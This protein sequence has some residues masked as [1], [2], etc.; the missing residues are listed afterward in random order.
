M[1]Q[2]KNHK[3]NK[4]ISEIEQQQKILRIKMRAANKDAILRGQLKL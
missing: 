4:K 2:R 3:G 1:N